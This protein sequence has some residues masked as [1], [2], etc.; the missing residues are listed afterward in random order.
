MS[1]VTFSFGGDTTELNQS[2]VQL[3]QNIS[4][5]VSQIKQQIVANSGTISNS[6]N[7]ISQDTNAGFLSMQSYA[8]RTIAVF[9]IA[10]AVIGSFS[11]ALSSL[12]G[13]MNSAGNIEAIRMNYIQFCGDVTKADILIE[14]LRDKS[15][16]SPYETNDLLKSGNALLSAGVE[17]SRVFDIVSSLAAVS[18][19]S[20]QTL[21]E[22]ALAMSKGFAR[23]KF[24]TEQVMAFAQRGINIMKPL[25]AVTGLTGD[26]LNKAI[27]KGLRFDQVAQAVASLSQE[28]GQFFGLMEKQGEGW[29]GLISTM[30]G[31]LDELRVSF[32]QPITEGLKPYLK[33]INKAI[34]DLIPKAAEAGSALI[35]GFSSALSGI[36]SAGSAIHKM[37]TSHEYLSRAVV[38]TIAVYALMRTGVVRYLQD[39]AIGIKTQLAGAMVTLRAQIAALSA[40][41]SSMRMSASLSFSGIVA[42]ARA[43]GMA[44]VV[45]FKSVFLAIKSSLVSTGIGIALVAIGELAA[46]IYSECQKADQVSQEM[47]DRAADFKKQ[48]RKE[49]QEVDSI[50]DELSLQNKREQLKND[51]AD[52]EYDAEEARKKGEMG[53]AFQMYAEIDAKEKLLNKLQKEAPARIENAKAIARQR[54]EQARLIQ[55]EQEAA[56]RARKNAQEAEELVKKSNA[57]REEKKVA[58]LSLDGQEVYAFAGAGV[59]GLQELEQR[60]MDLRRRAEV[61]GSLS[62]EDKSSLDVLIKSRDMLDEISQKRKEISLSMQQETQEYQMRISMIQAE[63]E[64]NNSKLAALRE[65]KK[66]LE[67]TEKFMRSGF[68]Q[69]TARKMAIEIVGLESAREQQ[70]QLNSDVSRYNGT[71]ADSKARVGGGGIGFTISVQ[72]LL[73]ESRKQTGVLEKIKEF[74]PK[75]EGKQ[76]TSTSVGIIGV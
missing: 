1:D 57:S 62:D 52:L 51:I 16:K 31:A 61:T 48:N 28:G 22:L 33:E 24:Q 8:N 20:G 60:I 59:N 67:E 23:G 37:V 6:F 55:M 36:Q 26:A 21:N 27:E 54:E 71:T 72:P 29:N 66:I 63:L 42:S 41:F 58:S 2:L 68:D 53:M 49:A 4:S 46:Y 11:G 35:K 73:N 30:M 47:N 12:K 65:Q 38:D 9:G 75:L 69:S 64:G 14:K 76:Q 3:R 39:M 13:A 17:A 15:V 44:M 40:S 34:G 74:L 32:A 10:K 45:S 7:S 70:D 50:D 56:E 25:A 5:F 18:G 19:G 43:A